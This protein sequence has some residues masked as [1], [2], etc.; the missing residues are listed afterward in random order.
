MK[1]KFNFEYDKLIEEEKRIFHDNLRLI[2]EDI[3]TFS[4][5]YG[6]ILTN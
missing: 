6:I 2:Q 3:L 4:L 1:I 5:Y